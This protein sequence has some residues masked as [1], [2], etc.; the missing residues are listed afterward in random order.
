MAIPKF[1]APETNQQ[2]TSEKKSKK[3]NSNTT[4]IPLLALVFLL[5]VAVGVLGFLYLDSKKEVD[6]LKSQ[7]QVDNTSEEYNEIVEELK[8]LIVVGED[9]RL[10]IA[11]VDKPDVLKE[12]DPKFYAD[13]QI[14]QYLVVLPKSQRVL[15]YDKENKKIVNFSSYTIKVDLI[16]EDQIPESEKPLTI[17]IRSVSDVTEETVT[18]V[19]GA[20]T[21]A[22]PSYSI[23]GTSK[24]NGE[25]YEGITLVLLNRDAKPKLSQNIVAHTGTNNILDQLPE[26]EAGS[27]ADVVIILGNQ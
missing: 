7:Q 20:L 23:T 12:Q 22:S 17:E 26:G 6:E 4:L 2:I 10:N 18:Q 24:T 3:K 27:E 21:N 13:V 16:P 19:Q 5:V 8:S 15:I 9:E 14:G 1:N 25:G 11:R